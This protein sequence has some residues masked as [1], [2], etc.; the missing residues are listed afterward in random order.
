MGDRRQEIMLWCLCVVS[1]VAYPPMLSA[2]VLAWR[3][4]YDSSLLA[5]LQITCVLAAV[6]Q[7]IVAVW[8]MHNAR[9]EARGADQPVSARRFVAWLLAQVIGSYGIL[10]GLY[11]A[12]AELTTL[13]FLW[14]LFLLLA[15]RPPGLRRPITA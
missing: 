4:A 15:L 11:R 9:A 3:P 7:T 1:T 6:A 13:F 2:L 14:S 8:L 10:T 5:S 12:P